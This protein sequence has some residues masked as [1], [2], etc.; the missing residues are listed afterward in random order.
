MAKATSMVPTGRCEG[1]GPE[2]L[3]DAMVF[4]CNQWRS[5]GVNFWRFKE[6]ISWSF[7]VPSC[8]FSTTKEVQLPCTKPHWVIVNMGI[9]TFTS[10]KWDID[11]VRTPPISDV[12]SSPQSIPR[13]DKLSCNINQYLSCGIWDCDSLTW[14]FN[15]QLHP[16]GNTW[17]PQSELSSHQ[18]GQQNT[19]QCCSSDTD[20]IWVPWQT[21][22]DVWDL[23]SIAT[24][25]IACLWAGHRCIETELQAP[26]LASWT[27][28][29]LSLQLCSYRKKTKQ[30]LC[31]DWNI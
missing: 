28:G 2:S 22:L 7:Q 24:L 10:W 11:S 9:F 29:L 15:L 1:G 31:L 25:R 8:R 12:K 21:V 18:V 6:R 16:T 23:L 30:I 17:S 13:S 5:W 19:Q 3:L 4:Y 20:H 14:R 27:S 26:K